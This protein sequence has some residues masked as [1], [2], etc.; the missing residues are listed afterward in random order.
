MPTTVAIPMPDSLLLRAKDHGALEQRS[1][2]LLALKY[3]EL[4]ELTS[5]QAAEMCGMSRIEFL[6]AAGRHGVPVADLEDDELIMEF[7]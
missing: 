6:F 3:F 7:S 5:G 4:H 1:R 2:F